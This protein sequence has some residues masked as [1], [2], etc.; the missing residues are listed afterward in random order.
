MS[1]NIDDSPLSCFFGCNDGGGFNRL[2]CH[3]IVVVA[4]VRLA[5]V[6]AARER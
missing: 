1:R 5:L 2:D 4:L 3:M 6:T